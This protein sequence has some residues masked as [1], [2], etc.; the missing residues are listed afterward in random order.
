MLLSLQNKSFA[1]RTISPEPYFLSLRLPKLQEWA[2]EGRF[3]PRGI[4]DIQALQIN[5]RSFGF[6]FFFSKNYL[7]NSLTSLLSN[8]YHANV[9][10][11]SIPK[12]PRYDE[13]NNWRSSPLRLGGDKTKMR[14]GACS[15]LW[16][17][18]GSFRILLFKD[19]SNLS[20]HANIYSVLLPNG[21]KHHAQFQTSGLR[22]KKAQLSSQDYSDVRGEGRSRQG[23]TSFVDSSM[24]LSTALL[25]AHCHHILNFHHHYYCYDIILLPIQG[26]TM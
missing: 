15:L 22:P 26:L 3:R 23:V 2:Q 8:W 24:S 17:H 16:T 5:L 6:V 10:W 7:L 25:R 20:E 21:R 11:A 12:K 1:D 19:Q 13:A 14:E 4:L 9:Y 18:P